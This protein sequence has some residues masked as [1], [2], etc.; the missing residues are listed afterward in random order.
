V[1][2]EAA[3]GRGFA[4]GRLL[5]LQERATAILT[6]EDLTLKT[7]GLSGIVLRYGLF[8]GEGTGS[9][10]PQGPITLHVVDAASAALLA[11]RTKGQGIFNIVEDGGPVSNGKAKSVLGWYPTAH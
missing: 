7:A 10:S 5:P 6:L 8:Y 2:A 1:K 3:I 4:S 9:D 11:T